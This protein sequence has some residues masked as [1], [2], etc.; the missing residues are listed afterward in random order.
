M[1]WPWHIPNHSVFTSNNHGF[2][3]RFPEYL[4]STG[5]LGHTND[6][7]QQRKAVYL[8]PV[9]HEKLAWV[10]W[11]KTTEKCILSQFWRLEVGRVGSS[12]RSQGR[13]FPL[14]SPSFNWL[15]AILNIPWLMAAQ[16]WFPALF[17]QEL[18][19][20]SLGIHLVSLSLAPFGTLVFGLKVYSK[21]KITSSE[22]I[23]L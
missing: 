9:C 12:W 19:P 16:L 21:S 17:P 13:I 2:Y 10:W 4:L 15:L 6:K 22:I 14:L 8:S 3:S 23:K 7:S 20:V 5:P 1:I 18:H 11:I